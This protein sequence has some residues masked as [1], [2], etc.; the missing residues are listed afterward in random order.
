M[1]FSILRVVKLLPQSI[2]EQL[3]HLIKEH[4]AIS[5]HSP[6]SSPDSLA[7]TNPLSGC[8]DLP[9]LDIS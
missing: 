6:V 8:L 1:I 4:I 2:L 9:V 3:N 5:S 7:T